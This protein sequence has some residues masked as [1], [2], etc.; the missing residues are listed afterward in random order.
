MNVQEFQPPPSR[1]A[2][3]FSL[4]SHWRHGLAL[5][6]L[7]L[8]ITFSIYWNARSQAQK[9]FYGFRLFPAREAFN[10]QLTDQ[11][12]RP[13]EL[14]NLRGQAVIFSFGFTHCPNICPSTLMDYAAIRNALPASER[15]QVKFLFVSVDYPRDKPEVLKK[16]LPYF[17][18]N[19]IGL[20]GQKNE[21][22][23]TVNAYGGSYEFVHRPGDDPDV[24]TVN[25]SAYSYL[26]GPKGKLQVLY[27][28]DKLS[29]P[30]KIVTDIRKVLAE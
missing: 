13:F 15:N 16:Y 6:V 11:D 12:G 19:I 2:P 4:R 29:D 14:A 25:H 9:D 22:D 27:D 21:I 28:Y 1:R 17:D 30:E 18:P 7:L 20:T 23:R 10:F 8:A 26:I 5:L 3:R 24:Y